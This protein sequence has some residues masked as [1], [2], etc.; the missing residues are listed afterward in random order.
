[1]TVE[2]E[3]N[4]TMEELEQMVCLVMALTEYLKEKG[5]YNEAVKY[6]EKFTKKM[7]VKN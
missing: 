5:L 7:E 3:L 6:V 1:M 2:E 4:E